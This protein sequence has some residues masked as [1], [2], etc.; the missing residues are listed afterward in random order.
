MMKEPRDDLGSRFFWLEEKDVGGSNKY[1]V[2]NSCVGE[3]KRGVGDGVKR[4]GPP[5]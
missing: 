4:N 1:L 5:W 2:G 3:K